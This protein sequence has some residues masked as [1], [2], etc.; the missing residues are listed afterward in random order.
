MFKH[1]RLRDY[2]FK[3]IIMVLAVS[4][5]GIVA[6]GSAKEALQNRQIAGVILGLFLMVTISFLDY[7]MLCKL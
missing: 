1:Y 2:D 6:I 3:L 4:T 7:S 5:I